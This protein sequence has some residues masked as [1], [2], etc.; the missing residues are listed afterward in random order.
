MRLC[1][2]ALLVL[3]SLA[4]LGAL[5]AEERRG[6]GIAR[7]LIA[8]VGQDL[9]VEM[10]TSSVNILGFDRKP[11]TR[12]E[13]LKLAAAETYLHKADAL[14]SL[15]DA[16]GCTLRE[17]QVNNALLDLVEGEQA[18]AYPDDNH[19]A[20]LVSEDASE[21]I[22]AALEDRPVRAAPPAQQ[23]S[24]PTSTESQVKT[25]D[26]LHSRFRVRSHFE[27]SNPGVIQ[28][29]KVTLMDNYRHVEKLRIQWLTE[30]D[31]GAVF[32][33]YRHDRFWLKR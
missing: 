1:H 26:A 30:D 25:S 15:P 10:E 11:R 14:L 33:K 29:L 22:E 16:A 3:M 21:A 12:T 9:E 6:D 5:A 23:A 2:G 17:V 8:A 18:E 24:S 20:H 13:F 7:M 31:Q 27:C 28:E 19:N 4:G 32:L